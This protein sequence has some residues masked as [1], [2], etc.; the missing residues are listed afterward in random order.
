MAGVRPD[1]RLGQP[2][3][4]DADLDRGAVAVAVRQGAVL[5]EARARA[6]L[7]ATA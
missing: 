7:D 3:A 5:F 1:A 6:A 2:A 4:A